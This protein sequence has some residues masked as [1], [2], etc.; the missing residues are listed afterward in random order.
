MKPRTERWSEGWSRGKV[1]T[2]QGHKCARCGTVSGLMAHDPT[3]KHISWRDGVVLCYVCHGKEH[4]DIPEGLFDRE[5]F[6]IKS[7]EQTSDNR[8][9]IAANIYRL[10]PSEDLSKNAFFLRNYEKSRKGY[11]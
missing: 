6:D 10:Y 4:P 3:G 1:L 8:A 11:I 9:R 5:H 2:S 7:E